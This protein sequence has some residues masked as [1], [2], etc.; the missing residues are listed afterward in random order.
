MLENLYIQPIGERWR[1]LLLDHSTGVVR[2]RGDGELSQLT[3]ELEEL[4]FSGS[5]RLMIPGDTV[6]LTSA[7]V[8]SKN[9]RQIIQA[10][11]FIVEEELATDVDDLHFAIGDRDSDGMVQVGVV[12]HSQ[13]RFWIDQ[14]NEAGLSPD[15]ARVDSILVPYQ[16]G[17]ISVFLGSE[18]VILR[19]TRDTALVCDRTSI[20]EL[21]QII[22]LQRKDAPVSVYVE[23]G[24][25]N[26]DVISQQLLVESEQSGDPIVADYLLFECCC[27]GYQDSSLEF[28]HGDFKV[29][30]KTRRKT[31]V[32]QTAAVLAT[33]GF[34][35][36]LLLLLSEGVYLSRQAEQLSAQATSLYQEVFPQDKNVRDLR[37]RWRAHLG[38]GG[39]ETDAAFLEAFGVAAS[40]LP[41]SNLILETINFNESRGDLVLQVQGERSEALVN[42]SEQLKEAGLAAEIGTISQDDNSVKGS[43]KISMGA[44]G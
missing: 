35:L 28:L 40:R 1:W 10:V 38:K 21:L 19:P 17:G 26:D 3:P 24:S 12:D 23:P 37:R 29:Q 44:S 30:Q 14:L 27:R 11:P 2:A 7:K 6:L 39:S 18:R 32:W 16:E 13:L 42:Y 15:L 8:P 22:R 36:H 33:A 9:R 34:V 41:D 4:Q 43:V 5:I 31:S 25:D 20:S